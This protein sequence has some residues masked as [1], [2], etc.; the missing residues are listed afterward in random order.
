MVFGSVNTG[1]IA[2]KKGEWVTNDFENWAGLNTSNG[3]KQT[4]TSTGEI[5]VRTD[6]VATMATKVTAETEPVWTEAMTNPTTNSVC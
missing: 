2:A 3:I 4:E 1:E 5:K 6:G